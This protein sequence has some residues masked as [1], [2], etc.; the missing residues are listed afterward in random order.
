LLP[1]EL[2]EIQCVEDENAKARPASADAGQGEKGVNAQDAEGNQ[3]VAYSL[4]DQDEDDKDDDD[5]DHDEVGI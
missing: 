4:L 5:D 2:E 1:E 3:R